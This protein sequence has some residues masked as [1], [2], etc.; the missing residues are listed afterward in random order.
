MLKTISVIGPDA[1]AVAECAAL[2]RTRVEKKASSSTAGERFEVVEG[3]GPEQHPDIVVA[4]V[5]HATA[6]DREVARAVAQA[7][8]VVLL[9]PFGSDAPSSEWA[10]IPGW[11]W[12]E[13]VDEVCGW[14]RALGV[15]VNEWEGQARRADAERLD[16]VRIATRLSATRISQEVLEDVGAADQARGTIGGRGA[17]G[18]RG[19]RG[20]RGADRFEYLHAAFMARLRLAVLEQGVVFPVLP[21]AQEEAPARPSAAVGSRASVVLAAAAGLAAGLG[22]GTMVGRLSGPVAG[23][24]VGVLVTLA[25]VGARLVMLRSEALKARAAKEDAALRQHWATV[26]TE[27]VARLEIPPVAPRIRSLAMEAN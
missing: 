23:V 15:D 4:A 19:V 27:V 25:V 2:L 18:A 1:R 11:V 14:I 6:E 26:V 7:M 10:S 24:I 12:C 9:W 13:D 8:G 5:G 17:G 22:L 3:A 20:A 21:E 16:R